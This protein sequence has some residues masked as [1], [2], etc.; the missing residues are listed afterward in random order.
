M[1]L[2][3]ISLALLQFCFVST[4]TVYVVF[5]PALL[6]QAGLAPSW[7]PVLLIADQA[8]FV[9]ADL[10][11]GVAADRSAAALRRLGPP[12]PGGG[13]QHESI[14]R[15]AAGDGSKRVG[16]GERRGHHDRGAGVGGGVPDEGVDHP[17]Q[18]RGPPLEV[19]PVA[20]GARP[21]TAMR[22]A[23]ASWA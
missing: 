1:N 20:S 16:A 11:A 14:R 5:L 4:W 22:A 17:G 9:L 15:C 10:A 3:G 8:V 6:A 18:D 13:D 21:G 2:T 12:E 19:G 23:A 7:L